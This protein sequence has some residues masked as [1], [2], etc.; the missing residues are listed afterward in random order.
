MQTIEKFYYDILTEQAE[1]TPDR[2]ALVMG[3]IR[4]TYRGLL[5]RIDGVAS[6]LLGKG[7]QKGD[8]VALWATAS[9]AWL[10]TY[11]G[12][13]RS[14]GI[15]LILN[16]NLTLK[17]AGPLVE[18]ADTKY[19]MFGKTHDIAGH[20]EDAEKLSEMY[21]LSVDHCISIL[22]E[23]FSDVPKITPD[24]TGWT[25]RDDAYIIYTSGTTAFPKA[26]LTSQY[27][28]TNVVRQLEKEIHP[29]RGEK[30]VLGV[31]L[32]HAY[33]IFVVWIYL[34]NGATLILPE[35]IKADIIA[36]LVE[37][38]DATDLWSVATI[39]QGIIDNEELC[40]KVAPRVRICSIAG[41][42]T[43]PVQFMRFEAALYNSTFINLY[44]MTE[45]S[46]TYTLTRPGDDISIRYNTVGRAV[47]G[48]EAAAWDEEH[49]ILPPGE[50]GEVITRGYHL[51]NSYYKLPPEKQ[52]V[53]K[54]GW[55]HSGDLGV[56]DEQGN[57]RIVGR[58]KDLIIKGGEN[59]A[60]AEIEA[61][62]MSHPSIAACRIFGYKDRIYGE[63]LAACVTL[64]P[65]ETFVEEEIKK[66]MKEKVG[67]YKSP[68]YYFV[69]ETF[70]LNANGK[71]DQRNLHIDM[72]RKLHKLMLEGK[73]EQGIQIIRLTM[74]NTTYNI[75]PV[76]ALFEECVLNL[77]CSRNKGMTIRLA[78]EEALNMRV[79]EKAED[80]GDIEVALYY[81]QTCLRITVTDNDM[82]GDPFREDQRRMAWAILLRLVDDCKTQRLE[83]GKNQVVIDFSYDK[84]FDIKDF[85]VDHEPIN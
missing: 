37:K 26:V 40:A 63:N 7:L 33:A 30:A 18:F 54:D 44:G 17:D 38:E 66:Y 29:I 41:S 36:N 64:A 12:I 48:V 2:E 83:N 23:D 34:S 77:G 43:S 71:I 75:T 8:K 79:N 80:I 20:A 47:D 85:L 82:E 1:K 67:S 32:F 84:D 57:L 62:V 19:L 78:V 13:I 55:L 49:G 56:F 35:A 11:Y 3:D 59:L 27:A 50:V 9:P 24:T 39:Y 5:N 68:V 28:I 10:Y 6:V 65:G 60:P 31:P 72:L 58:I 69:Y 25:V 42:Y 73:L 16:A 22:D 4:L 14:G 70:P 45:T 21:G 76:S 51:K 15:A 61:Q 52:A 74:K 46:A 53:D 81:M